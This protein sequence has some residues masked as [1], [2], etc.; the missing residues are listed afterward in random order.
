MAISEEQFTVLG[1]I[2]LIIPNKFGWREL[3]RAGAQSMYLKH[4]NMSSIHANWLLRCEASPDNLDGN[5]NETRRRKHER[6]DFIIKC[7][8]PGIAWEKFGVRSDIVV[9]PSVESCLLK[10]IKL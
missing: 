5:L 1:R 4:S 9:G 3:F 7:F 6:T 8:D 10:L 2:L